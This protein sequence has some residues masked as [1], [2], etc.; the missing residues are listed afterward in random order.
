MWEGGRLLFV[1]S[2]GKFGGW[3]E[4]GESGNGEGVVDFG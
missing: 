2:N 4:D 3:G 1:I